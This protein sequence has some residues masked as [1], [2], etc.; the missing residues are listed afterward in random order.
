MT[1]ST[2]ANHR[3]VRSPRPTPEG[4]ARDNPIAGP[5]TGTTG[6]SPPPLPRQRPR[7][8]TKS[9]V[10]GRPPRALRRRPVNPGAQA[11]GVHKG[12]TVSGQPTGAPEATGPD[13]ARRTIAGVPGTPERHA[14]GHN[15]GTR[16]G[17][18][19]QR[20]PGAAN[21]DSAHNPEQTTAQEQ[22]PGD[23][24]PTNRTPQPGVVG[25]KPSAH[26]NTHTRPSNPAGVRKSAFPML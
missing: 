25:H 9:P 7:A 17:A 5:R 18:K 26:T 19:Q 13:E 20:P 14:T 6:A 4:P 22:V 15:Q 21:L 2:H 8:G 24:Q 23:T 16:T 3:T 12:T 1:G 10:L 11:P